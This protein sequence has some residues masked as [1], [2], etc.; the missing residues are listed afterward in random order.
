M[1]V[2]AKMRSKALVLPASF[3]AANGIGSIYIDTPSGNVLTFRDY[4]SVDYPLLGGTVTSS[5]LLLKRKKNGTLLTIPV[6]T[7]VAVKDDGT[8]V[9][10]DSD[11]PD[12][13]QMIG[14][15]TE[16][17]LAGDYGVILLIGANSSNVLDG[18]GFTT[19][20]LIYLGSTPGS[21]TNDLATI[22]GT[23]K[24]AGI[25]DCPTD[26]FSSIATDLILTSGNGGGGAGGGSA[27]V[28][29]AAT[30]LRG[31]PVS[32][33]ASGSLAVV[34]ITDEDSSYAFCGVTS[35]DCLINGT[36][37]VLTAGSVLLDIPAVFGL[38]GQYGKHIF[39][40]H[41][42]T[43]TMVKPTIGVGG[44]LSQDFIISVG[45]TTK[46]TATATT[47]LILN[48]RIIGRLA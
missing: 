20:E 23:V 5:E 42:G 34:D 45:I 25:A 37:T 41:T 47:D 46:N 18:M 35:V 4:T 16:A 17:I 31:Y 33:N 26:D 24:V 11:D 14:T 12:A 9:P 22:V 27:F 10:T 2:Y 28:K 7:T 21:L 13:I 39:V 38:T 3:P 6:D 8:I 19:G 36:D 40:S 44:F 43:L 32:I 30:I 15:T 29:A 1:P 48:P